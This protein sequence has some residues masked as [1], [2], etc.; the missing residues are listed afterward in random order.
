MT[1]KRRPEL[2]CAIRGESWLEQP[3][4][5]TLSTSRATV[6]AS[7]RLTITPPAAARAALAAFRR[8]NGQEPGV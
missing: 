5:A 4:G 6:G 7:P 3:A 2:A 1:R 8:R